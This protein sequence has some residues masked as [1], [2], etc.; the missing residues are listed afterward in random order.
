M[1]KST[2]IAFFKR[3]QGGEIFH[4]YKVFGGDGKTRDV[5]QEVI[6][7]LNDQPIVSIEHNHPYDPANPWKPFNLT[8]TWCTYE[9]GIPISEQEYQQEYQKAVANDFFIG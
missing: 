5:Y 2:E 4:Y 6:N 7:F 3:H 1:C 9:V 8:G